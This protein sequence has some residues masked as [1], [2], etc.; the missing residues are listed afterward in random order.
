MPAEA[1]PVYSFALTGD[2][3]ITKLGRNSYDINIK[4]SNKDENAESILKKFEILKEKLVYHP[5]II[6]TLMTLPSQPP[7]VLFL[8]YPYHVRKNGMDK[9]IIRLYNKIVKDSIIYHRIPSGR[10]IN[11]YFEFSNFPFDF[12][13]VRCPQ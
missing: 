6:Y 2:I 9:I 5:Q 7:A 4:I 13:S 1:K 10:F 11:A 12:G 8:V 3:K